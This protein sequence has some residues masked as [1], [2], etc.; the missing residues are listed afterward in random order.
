[1]QDA[2]DADE[3]AAEER[4]EAEKEVLQ[5]GNGKSLF[6]PLTLQVASFLLMFCL[7]CFEGF[8]NEALTCR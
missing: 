1:M 2:K 3:S 4:D 6:C 8:L 7:C 5:L